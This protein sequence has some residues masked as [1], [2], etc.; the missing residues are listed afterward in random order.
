MFSQILPY[1]L[2]G[3]WKFYP[4]FDLLIFD[5]NF[6]ITYFLVWIKDLDFC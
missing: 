2:A 1:Q 5:E 4:G 3:T 6:N